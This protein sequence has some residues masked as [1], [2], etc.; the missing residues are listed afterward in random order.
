MFDDDDDDDNEGETDWE[1]LADFYWSCLY[2]RLVLQ[3]WK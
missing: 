2:T 3:V 1:K